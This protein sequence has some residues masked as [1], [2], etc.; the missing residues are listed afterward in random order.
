M[1]SIRMIHNISP[2]T[3]PNQ[4][5]KV[6]CNSISL[7][8][9]AP[10]LFAPT[11]VSHKIPALFYIDSKCR[12]RYPARNAFRTRTPWHSHLPGY[13]IPVARYGLLAGLCKYSFDV[14]EMALQIS[15]LGEPD[16][17]YL[18][19]IIDIAKENSIDLSIHTKRLYDLSDVYRIADRIAE[20]TTNS[21]LTLHWT[22]ALHIPFAA[23]YRL[24]QQGTD[25]IGTGVKLAKVLP[26]NDKLRNKAKLASDYMCSKGDTVACMSSKVFHNTLY[27]LFIKRQPQGF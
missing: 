8:I 17:K 16:E 4:H 7:P 13:F 12:L 10:P 2:T 19:P 3:A 6:N 24:Y 22:P 26:L 5:L 18:Q 27:K 14:N 9:H 20:L 1:A 25:L 21:T 23:L 15:C 11:S